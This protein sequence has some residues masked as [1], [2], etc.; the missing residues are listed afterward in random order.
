MDISK[1]QEFAEKFFP[2]RFYKLLKANS[3]DGI[4][5]NSHGKLQ[6][7][8][9]G[10]DGSVPLFELTPQE[11]TLLDE[12]LSNSTA[13]LL[14]VGSGRVVIECQ[15][16]ETVY[17]IARSGV[18]QYL[19]DGREA[20][21]SEVERF[22]NTDCQQLLPV[23]DFCSNFYWLSMPKAK[24]LTMYSKQIHQSVRLY[25]SESISQ[26][27]E[28]PQEDILADNIG[29]WE[30][31]WY[32]LDYGRAHREDADTFGYFMGLPSSVTDQE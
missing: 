31:D 5:I 6:C 26:Y 12:F 28:I 24:V 2:L 3:W 27:T 9:G 10:I 23:T 15:E 4:Q 18:S 32:L 21:K 11:R 22:Q 13:R 29:F 20:N 25:I 7:W 17:K 14:G 8:P 16:T 30:D 19:G 1:L